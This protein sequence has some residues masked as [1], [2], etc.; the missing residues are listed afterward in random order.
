VSDVQT[1]SSVTVTI[2]G[3]DYTIRAEATPEY[4]RRCAEYVDR[5]IAQIL[6]KSGLVE[7]HKAAIL[8]ALSLSDQ[9]FQARAELDALHRE[10][11]NATDKLAAEVDATLEAGDL[12]SLP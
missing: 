7:G 6:E 8:A 3:E 4:M 12:A 11:A 10:F 1:K 9:L 2:A 5:T